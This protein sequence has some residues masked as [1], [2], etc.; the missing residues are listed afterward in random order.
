MTV[1]RYKTCGCGCG[2]MGPL[3]SK[4]ML[5][6]CWK[7]NYGKK[8]DKTSVVIRKTSVK[9]ISPRHAEKMKIYYQL[10]V[11]FLNKH[12]KCEACSVL[13]GELGPNAPKCNGIATEVHHKKGRGAHLLE[14]HTWMAICRPCHRFITD[15]SALAIR[16]GL[17]Y[18]RIASE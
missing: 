17:S 8:P 18:N 2:K 5:I 16:L 4:G 15:N 7:K 13:K 10:R 9:K 6:G 3:F 1:R 11:E 12:T 14:V